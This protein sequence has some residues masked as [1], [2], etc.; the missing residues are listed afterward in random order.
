MSGDHIEKTV[1][2]LTVDE[3]EEFTNV[4]SSLVRQE[5]LA[6][7]PVPETNSL[8]SGN[9]TEIDDETKE[10]RIKEML[11]TLDVAR[12]TLPFFTLH[13]PE[14]NQ[15]SQRQ[16]LDQTEPE[17]D[18][19]KGLDTKGVDGDNKDDEDGDPSSG[20]DGRVPESTADERGSQQSDRD[21][22]YCY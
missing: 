12:K 18:F 14:Q 13:S 10:R 4:A 21:D 5:R 6:V 3:S 20:V 19:S 11:A 8:L 17:F 1:H 9:T 15:S 7:L 22:L 16:D 2:R